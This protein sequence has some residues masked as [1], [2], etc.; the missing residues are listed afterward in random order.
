[1]KREYLV[2]A[3]L[4]AFLLFFASCARQQFTPTSGETTASSQPNDTDRQ[5]PFSGSADANS[6][7]PPPSKPIAAQNVPVGTPISIR[8]LSAVSSATAVPGQQFEATL[9]QPLVLNGETIAAAGTHVIGRVVSARSSGRLHNPGYLRLTLISMSLNGKTVPLQTSSIFVKGVS[10][11]NR[12][13]A[14]LGGGAGAGALIG[15]I[16]GGGRGALIG[17]AIGATAGAAG[18]YGTGK[19]EVGFRAER[20]LTF[21]LMQ[22]VSING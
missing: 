11:K 22:P 8:L 18:A 13:I 12:N 9:D 14:M 2:T 7:P 15:G 6:T 20:R 5:L 4:T 21:R 16:A 19:R 3:L 10:H 1:M 17:S